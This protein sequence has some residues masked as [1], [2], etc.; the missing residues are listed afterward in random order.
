[1]RFRRCRT[2][3]GIAPLLPLGTALSDEEDS[4]WYNEHAWDPSRY[5]DLTIE[6]DLTPADWLR[7]LLV[8]RSFE[9]WMTAPRGYEEYAR[10]F[11]PLDRSG[12]DDAGEWHDQHVRWTDLAH[13]NG[14]IAHA[15][16]NE[17]R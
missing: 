14:R 8:P 5:P 1:M 10:I 7:P 12:V 11:F 4:D 13:A 16:R 9:V 15:L 6:T 3:Q 2:W 17:R